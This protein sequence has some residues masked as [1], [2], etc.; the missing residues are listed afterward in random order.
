MTPTDYYKILG[1]PKTAKAEQIKEAYRKLAFKYHPDRSGEAGNGDRMKQIN[2]AYAALSDPA[3]RQE[4][5]SLRSQFGPGAYDQFRQTYSEQ[6]IFRDTDIHQIFEE[7]ARSFGL[8]GFDE[9]FKNFYGDGMRTFKSRGT[10]FFAGGFI[11]SGRPGH[12]PKDHRTSLPRRPNR[13]INYLFNKV[14]GLAIP[15]KGSDTHDTIV[16]HPDEAQKGGPYAYYHRQKAKKLV[17]KIPPGIRDGQKIRLTG[18]GTDGRSGGETGDLYLAV[19]I[20][21]P[22][23]DKIK[24][25]VTRLLH[26]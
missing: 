6:E 22:L 2:E 10:G 8:W 4:Y 23:G 18:M 19:S 12:F 9:I 16:L 25:A 14:T 24:K 15:Q 20:K 1:I 21:E 17:V 13:L 7:M 3:K 5:D 11:F 26:R